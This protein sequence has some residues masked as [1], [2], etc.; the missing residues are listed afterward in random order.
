MIKH[1]D[2]LIFSKVVVDD[3]FFENP[4]FGKS[5]TDQSYYEPS[6]TFFANQQKIGA[7][8]MSHLHNQAESDISQVR[9]DSSFLPQNLTPEEIHSMISQQRELAESAVND[10]NSQIN[11]IKDELNQGQTVVQ[12]SSESVE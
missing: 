9:K 7:S 8:A 2:D 12:N 10:V 4:E 5:N 1:Y 11:Q 3:Y 6:G